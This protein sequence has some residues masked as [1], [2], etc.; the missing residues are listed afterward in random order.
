MPTKIHLVKAMVFP[1]VMYGCESWTI[2]KAG[3][4]ELWCWR[5]L[6]IVSWTAR[7]TN[8]SILNKISPEYS[9]EELMLKLKLPY[10]GHLMQ[11][12]DI[13]KNPDAGKDWRWEEKGT[14]E[15]KMVGWHHWLDGHDFKQTLR[16]GDGQE[17]LACYS[18]WG[19]KES[20]MAEWLNWTVQYQKLEIELPY[21]PAIPL[22]SIHTKETRTERNTWTPMFVAAL[23]T[24]ARTWKQANVHWQKNG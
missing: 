17:G 10:Y 2:K 12:T 5:R 4:F 8:Q 15:D 1:V 3:A 9:F 14:A 7:R 19:R 6:L 13:W 22:L 16:V 20:D 11:R 21:N 18:P 23:F 24:I